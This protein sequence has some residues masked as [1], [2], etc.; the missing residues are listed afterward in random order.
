MDAPGSQLTCPACG[1]AA[2]A[3][4]RFCSRCGARLSAPEPPH[5]PP[6]PEPQPPP[7]E[8]PP[9]PVAPQQQQQ[10]R[11]ALDTPPANESWWRNPIVVVAAAVGILFGGG[12]ASWRFF[13]S[14]GSEAVPVVHMLSDGSRRESSTTSS[15]AKTTEPPV[16]DPA[17]EGATV[18]AIAGIVRQSEAGRRALRRLDYVAALHNRQRLVVAMDRLD[19]PPQPERLARAAA[20]LRAALAA[21]ARAD[22]R[23]IACGCDQRLS[24]DVYAHGLKHRFAGQFDPYARRY[25]GHPVDPERI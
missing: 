10:Q 15:P 24:Q 22:E 5:V 13:I 19:V 7:E 20:T 4:R 14:A 23:H 17:D 25:L 18:T 21:S 9:A 12:V 11:W 3:D 2:P 6:A 8:P 16:A 1:Q